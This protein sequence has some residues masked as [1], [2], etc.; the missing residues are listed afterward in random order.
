MGEEGFRKRT[1]IQ[2]SH[3]TLSAGMIYYAH[4]LLVLWFVTE[5]L[6]CIKYAWCG[7]AGTTCCFSVDCGVSLMSFC[8]PTIT[9]LLG[10]DL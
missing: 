9:P 4:T 1:L 2:L 3:T 8:T 5:L 10:T 6:L 7:A